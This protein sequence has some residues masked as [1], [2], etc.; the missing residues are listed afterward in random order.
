MNI[1]KVLTILVV[2]VIVV[3]LLLTVVLLVQASNPQAQTNRV[4]SSSSSKSSVSETSSSTSSKAESKWEQSAEGWTNEGIETNCESPSFNSPV[5][6]SLVKAILYPGQ[7]RSGFKPHGGFIFNTKNNTVE[8]KA[9]FDAVLVEGS[10]YIEGGETQYLFRFISDCGIM[11]AF[12]HILTP[13]EELMNIASTFPEAKVNDSRTTLVNPQVRFAEG[14]ILATEVGF[15]KTKNYS[16]DFGVY[17][18]TTKNEAS[19]DPTFVTKYVKSYL[20]SSALC[21]LDNLNE[22]DKTT[23]KAL[24]GGDSKAKKTSFYCK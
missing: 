9:P 7:V 3:V 23:L 5:N 14:D 13:S 8:V 19:N 1:K 21:W 10:R 4:T 16:M 2:V 22:P 17:D 6:T 12:D 24:P 11:Y 20:A 18:L 15:K